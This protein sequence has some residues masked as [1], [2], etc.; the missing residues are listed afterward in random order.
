MG[1]ALKKRLK[2]SKFESTVQ[3]AL[4]SLLV[5]ASHVRERLELISAEHGITQTQYNVLRILKGAY[6]QGYPRC[7]IAVRMIEKAP[8]VTRLI[9]RLEDQGLV[10]RDRS[11]SDRRLSITRITPR[12]VELLE[13]M[14]ASFDEVHQYF[15]ERIS[16]RDRRE[17]SRICEGLYSEDQ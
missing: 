10:E 13:R 17:L 5:A 15:A 4:L 12:G 9:D 11:Q 6:P 7:D 16:L 2:Q 8:D 14:R 3:E 1:E